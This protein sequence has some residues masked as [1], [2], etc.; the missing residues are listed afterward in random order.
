MQLVGSELFLTLFQGLTYLSLQL[1]YCLQLGRRS[2]IEYD[3]FHELYEN[4]EYIL[5]RLVGLIHKTVDLLPGIQQHLKRGEGCSLALFLPRLYALEGELFQFHSALNPNSMFE[6]PTSLLASQPAFLKTL[7]T[8][9]GAPDHFSLYDDLPGL[10][11]WNLYRVLRIAI[12]SS[13][14]RSTASRAGG[15][16]MPYTEQQSVWTICEL[17]EEMR[18][19]VYAHFIIHISGKP[20][21]ADTTSIIGLRQIFLLLPLRMAMGYIEALPTNPISK[22]R[23]NWVQRVLMFLLYLNHTGR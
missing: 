22:E 13:I 8:L 16:D 19:S 21:A 14:L 20:V 11:V 7:T 3:Y 1:L 9:P 10:Y 12:H 15:P 17:F 23:W 6:G 2:Y 18:S 5:A 4:S